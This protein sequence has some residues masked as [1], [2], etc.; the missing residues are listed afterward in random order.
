MNAWKMDEPKME[1]DTR[2][3][4]SNYVHMECAGKKPKIEINNSWGNVKGTVYNV[5]TIFMAFVFF[6]HSVYGVLD[7]TSMC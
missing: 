4:N 7:T 3:C 2:C 1:I 6:P 5:Y